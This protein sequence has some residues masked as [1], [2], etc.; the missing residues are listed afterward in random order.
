MG[1]DLQEPVVPPFPH[2]CYTL[3]WKQQPGESAPQAASSSECG[4]A[5]P[6]VPS[7]FFPFLGSTEQGE[8]A[9]SIEIPANI[10]VWLAPGF[11]TEKG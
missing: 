6:L 9:R 3:T 7:R 11:S 8:A 2:P 10:H 4:T 1:S 5:C